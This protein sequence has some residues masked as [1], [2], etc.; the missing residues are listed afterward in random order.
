MNNS[1]ALKSIA[2][3]YNTLFKNTKT[4][5]AF[6]EALDSKQTNDL[7]DKEQIQSIEKEYRARA[8]ELER[9]SKELDKFE[10]F[11]PPSMY[12]NLK[13]AISNELFAIG[14]LMSNIHG[15][16]ELG[17]GELLD[18]ITEK[19]DAEKETGLSLGKEMET[20]TN[21][22]AFN[23]FMQARLGHLTI[24]DLKLMSLAFESDSVLFDKINHVIT[25]LED[26]D[27][28]KRISPELA[29][30]LGI[31]LP[32]EKKEQ[33]VAAP[34][35]A[36]VVEEEK[37]ATVA[38]P[39]AS[40]PVSATVSASGTGKMKPI[41]QSKEANRPTL[42]ERISTVNYK[43]NG[44]INKEVQE[45][46]L[47]SRLETVGEEIAAL[48]GKEKRTIRENF[49]LSQLLEEQLGLQTYSQ[50]ISDQKLSRSEERRERGLK[51]T[52]DRLTSTEEQ[53]AEAKAFGEQYESKIMRFLSA[54]Y[55]NHLSERIKGLQSKQGE[56]TDLQRMS[57]VARFDKASRKIANKA[58]R[59]GNLAQL[60]AYRD[61]IV[62]EIELMSDDLVRFSSVK[63]EKIPQ[64]KSG[65]V[66]M[67]SAILALNPP[68]E[69]LVAGVRMAA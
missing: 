9:F 35:A 17:N 57:S 36:A 43:L 7:F 30:K 5:V 60:K 62:H 54:R 53:L 66:V 14:S 45:I 51:S 29:Q 10:K 4:F 46:S 37:E 52:S 31:E 6:R 26:D 67:F 12:Q 23:L 19:F 28:I 63:A 58:R 56:L 27:L 20:F 13:K 8:M 16:L 3:S 11:M 32:A 44:N 22:L 42:Q 38:V 47:E 33:V 24:E 68:Q 21:N 1:A 49:R 69:E 40:A 61:Q 48:Q 41:E 18:D 59:K 2:L 25:M 39:T 55:Q 50:T 64:M 15:Y 65:N 34:A